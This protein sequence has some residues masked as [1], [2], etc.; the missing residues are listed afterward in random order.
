MSGEL[1]QYFLTQA[2]ALANGEDLGT[3]VERMESSGVF[4]RTN[5]E[6]VKIQLRGALMGHAMFGGRTGSSGAL[7]AREIARHLAVRDIDFTL[8]I[9]V[10]DA[11]VCADYAVA[12]LL[13]L[14]GDP[15]DAVPF[16]RELV[17]TARTTEDSPT[18]L[19]GL[20]HFGRLELELG[21]PDAAFERYAEASGWLSLFEESEDALADLS[22]QA[23]LR[24]D[25]RNV[26]DFG[27]PPVADSGNPWL[28]RA[29]VDERAA[30]ALLA[31][32]RAS[33]A[34]GPAAEAYLIWEKRL[35][36]D[37]PQVGVTILAT[38]LEA[39]TAARQHETALVVARHLLELGAEL[40]D[41]DAVRFGTALAADSWDALGHHEDAAAARA[42]LADPDAR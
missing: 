25:N 21:R 24:A 22:S 14:E 36:T 29:Y 37:Y 8:A 15:V 16:V 2:V 7:I 20:E 35:Q 3:I 26:F 6:D 1:D 13:E 17:D 34:T 42:I 30:Q 40:G 28:L 32:G 19:E 10:A 41:A 11:L 12:T 33:E 31:D 5:G 27:P 38:Q 9:G 4:D 23:M 39:L 18:L